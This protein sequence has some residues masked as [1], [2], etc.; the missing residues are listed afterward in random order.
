V[1]HKS[2]TSEEAKAVTMYAVVLRV[3]RPNYEVV[4]L[5]DTSFVDAGPSSY[6][7]GWTTT[8]DWPNNIWPA[9]LCFATRELAAAEA[10]K[11]QREFDD[12]QRK[13]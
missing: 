4:E 11:C 6:S 12:V 10:E 8:W 7:S 9:H 2:A 3:T 13:A 1:T 5:R